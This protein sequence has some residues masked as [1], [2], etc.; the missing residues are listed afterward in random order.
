MATASIIL[1][2]LKQE[3]PIE[4]NKSDFLHNKYLLNMSLWYNPRVRAKLTIDKNVNHCQN[5]LYTFLTLREL[6]IQEFK[7]HW[8]GQGGP[9]VGT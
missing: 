5:D 1:R 3:E 4:K 9:P 6:E 7:G 8:N 2:T